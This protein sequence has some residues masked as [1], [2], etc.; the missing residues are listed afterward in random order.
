MDDPR[1]QKSHSPTRAVTQPDEKQ[2]P[3]HNEPDQGD[4]PNHFLAQE[5]RQDF[6]QVGEK[7][8]DK[9]L[10]LVTQIEE[11]GTARLADHETLTELSKE[12]IQKQA[13]LIRC[14]EI[15]LPFRNLGISD[16]SGWVF[17]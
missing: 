2:L 16:L 13:D 17:S 5:K 1:R 6:K 8:Y 4:M 7:R 12:L 15:H 9:M 11:M 10:E 14:Q 3:V